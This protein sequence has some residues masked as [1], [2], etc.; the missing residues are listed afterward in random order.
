VT[1]IHDDSFIGLVIGSDSLS[2]AS[3]NN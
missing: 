1:E 2:E 3:I